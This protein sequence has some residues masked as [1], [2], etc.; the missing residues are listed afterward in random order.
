MRRGQALKQ[1]AGDPKIAGQL[2]SRRVVAASAGV[3]RSSTLRRP[4]CVNEAALLQI[5]LLRWSGGAPEDGIAMRE[6]AEPGNYVK[7]ATCL[8]DGMPIKWF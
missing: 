1:H 5:R 6:S 7:M 2:K 3:S 8:A 4:P